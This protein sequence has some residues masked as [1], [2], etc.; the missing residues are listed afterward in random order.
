MFYNSYD[1]SMLP[2]A[3]SGEARIEVLLRH[4]AYFVKSVSDTGVGPKG[5]VSFAKF[6]GPLRA[7]EVAV[8]RAGFNLDG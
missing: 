4:K 6:G 8:S 2:T 1:L 5:Q 3:S 7:W